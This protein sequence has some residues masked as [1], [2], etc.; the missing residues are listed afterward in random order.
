MDIILSGLKLP[1]PSIYKIFLLIML[2]IAHMEKQSWVFPEP[3][4]PAISIRVPDL[5]S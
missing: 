3:F 2:F 4:L 5:G 1:E